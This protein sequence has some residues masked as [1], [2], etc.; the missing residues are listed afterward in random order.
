MMVTLMVSPPL[1]NDLISGPAKMK[2]RFGTFRV[3]P[4]EG[5]GKT[6]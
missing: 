3:N 5:R 6:S 1:T 4:G 2:V